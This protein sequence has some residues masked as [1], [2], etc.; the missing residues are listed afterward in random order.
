[1]Q[2]VQTESHSCVFCSFLGMPQPQ[3]P[4]PP[5]QNEGARE[6]LT[7]M[8]RFIWRHPLASIGARVHSHEGPLS[9]DEI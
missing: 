4:F 2:L 9:F 5:P 3:V 6:M 1:M 8:F 7:Q